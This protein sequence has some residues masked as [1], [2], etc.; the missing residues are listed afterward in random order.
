MRALHDAV[1]VGGDRVKLQR[2]MLE[3]PAG[4]DLAGLSFVIR[5][6]DST[7]WWRDGAL[8]SAPA[9]STPCPC[10]CPSE[11][12]CNLGTLSQTISSAHVR[13]RGTHNFFKIIPWPD[14]QAKFLSAG[15]WHAAHTSM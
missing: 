10:P 8:P 4:H 14:L 6:A 7:N 2:V 5:S 12:V 3:V 11:L 13:A 9:F 1:Q 15:S